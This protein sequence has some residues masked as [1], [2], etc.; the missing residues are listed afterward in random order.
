MK[1]SETKLPVYDIADAGPRNRFTIR[2]ARGPMIV[3]NCILGLGYG[4]GAAK[5]QHALAN[6]FIKVNLPAAEC[7][8]IVK[9]YRSQYDTIPRLWKDCQNAITNMYNGFNSTVGVAVQLPVSGADHTVTLPNGM[10]LRYPDLQCG[11]NERGYPEYSYQKKRFRARL[12]GGSLT[13][14]LIQGS[15]S[16]TPVPKPN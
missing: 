5:L 4:T 15:S 3:H 10:K 14:N 13:E 1:C 12:Y 11:T 7:E 2:T 8:R 6:G 9:L 16:K